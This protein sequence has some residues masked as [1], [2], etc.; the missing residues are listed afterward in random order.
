MSTA[1]LP[2]R[3]GDLIQGKYRVERVIGR[4]GMG[5][6]VAAKHVQL[7]STV[8]IKLL[9]A[10]DWAPDDPAAERFAR[11]AHT[12]V[13]L[14]S[15]KSARVLDVDSL[16]D[17]TPFIVMEYLVGKDLGTVLA[18]RGALPEAEAV[19]Y[20]LQAC[21]AVAEAHALGIVHRDLKPHN[22]F[23]TEA[24]D[25][26][27]LV[28]VLDF[29]VAK[30]SEP[31]AA[32]LTITSRAMG[33]PAYM[34]PEQ[35]RAPKE[36]D[37]RSDVWSLGVCAYELLTGV[38]PFQAETV[39]ALCAVVLTETPRPPREIRP[40]LSPDVAAVVMRCLEKRPRD[41]HQTVVEL[42]EALE[43]ASAVSRRG[44]VAAV[45]ARAR[46]VPADAS[47]NEALERRATTHLVARRANETRGEAT[48]DVYAARTR[49]TAVWGFGGGILLA[50]FVTALLW[51]RGTRSVPEVPA[52]SAAS[53]P[54]VATLLHA[55]SPPAPPPSDSVAEE[56]PPSPSPS[57]RRQGT[58]QHP[59]STTRDAGAHATPL[60]DV[61]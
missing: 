18:E 41:R 59:R 19:G 22:L 11:E 16:P 36:V 50:S 4:G 58:P 26:A 2:I 15:E 29:G 28:K 31:T 60:T 33:T 34:S 32:S 27:P 40:E 51:A 14:R 17:G 7:G 3:P 24:S 6:V 21:E 8:A 56:P 30:W 20:V 54:A 53:A 44:R 10:E 35:M 55:A 5:V 47:A 43:M 13:R 37:A 25:G 49:R 9:A 38:P 46:E 42:A 52:S 23:L 39:Q 45:A 1:K 48:T 12:A 57:P 61:P